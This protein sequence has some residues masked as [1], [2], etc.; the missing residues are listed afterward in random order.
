MSIAK[1]RSG[2]RRRWVFA[3]ALLALTVTFAV[4]APASATQSETTWLRL[5]MR[6]D[7]NSDDVLQVVL[8][9]WVDGSSRWHWLPTGSLPTWLD[10]EWDSSH[11]TA[12]AR[13]YSGRVIARW[14]QSQDTAEVGF[15]VEGRNDIFPR[16][17]YVTRG[18]YNWHRTAWFRIEPPIRRESQQRA[19]YVA[20]FKIAPDIPARYNLNPYRNCW[21]GHCERG[22]WGYIG[23]HSGWDAHRPGR[24][25]H[26]FSLSAGQVM[27]IERGTSD[28]A[29]L[30]AVLGSD[31]HLVTYLHHDS[32][33]VTEGQY[34]Q[35][36]TALGVQ[37]ATGFS[38]NE[39][40][41]VEV[42]SPARPVDGSQF[43]FCTESK[44]AGRSYS[45]DPV[46]YLYANW[47]GP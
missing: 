39:H 4:T 12:L 33:F 2:A 40:V 41:H 20:L 34:V 11:E 26:F 45:V 15:R 27:C 13:G 10:A 37:G 31:G 42:R 7:R 25:H 38:T 43:T 44:G 32:A 21:G 46:D 6:W 22:S 28:N 18:N 8:E 1:P 30:I 9:H 23:G 14:S 47:I 35:V 3:I 19:L 5:W 36:G 24:G 17:R 16:D 29:G